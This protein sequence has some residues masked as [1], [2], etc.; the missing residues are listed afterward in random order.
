MSDNIQKFLDI[1]DNGGCVHRCH[2]CPIDVD[3]RRS[4]PVLR[5]GWLL[6]DLKMVK[7]NG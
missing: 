7:H 1:L 4:C 5:V 6:L 3:F 2:T